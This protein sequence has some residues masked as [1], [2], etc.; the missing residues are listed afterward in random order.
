MPLAYWTMAPGAGQA[1]RHPG[2]RSACTGPCASA[3]AARRL[4]SCSRNLIRFQKFAVVSGS[5]WYV[6]ICTVVS[7]GRSFH[8]WHATSQAL[9]PMHVEVSTSFVIIGSDARPAPAPVAETRRSSRVAVT[10]LVSLCRGAPP[11]RPVTELRASALGVPASANSHLVQLHEKAL[12]LGRERV[13]ID[14]RRRHEVGQRATLLAAAEEAPVDREPDLVDRRPPTC[15]GLIR[16]VTIARPSIDSARRRHAHAI[17]GSRCPSPRAS[18]SGISTKNSG[19]SCTVY[20]LFF[21]Q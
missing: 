14:D 21:V 3:S 13:R 7:G 5:V 12:V 20:G 8:S 10:T 9:Q 18:S 19:W 6:P 16:R 2:R 15:I 11:P 4:S 1:M 17:S